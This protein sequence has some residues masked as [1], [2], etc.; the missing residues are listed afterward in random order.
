MGFF[1]FKLVIK[2]QFEIVILNSVKL[3]LALT[4]HQGTKTVLKKQPYYRT[5]KPGI[6]KSILY[7]TLFRPILSTNY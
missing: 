2:L 5:T 6:V 7:R 1:Y 4:E 3:F